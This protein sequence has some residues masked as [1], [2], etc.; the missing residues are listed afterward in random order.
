M[1]RSG[2]P[3]AG[4]RS[5][6]LSTVRR[7]RGAATSCCR[8]AACSTAIVTAR[9][10]WHVCWASAGP[11]PCSRRWYRRRRRL[12]ARWPRSAGPS[13]WRW[14][15]STRRCASPS[16]PSGSSGCW[17]TGTST[18]WRCPT[19][20]GPGSPKPCA[21]VPGWVNSLPWRRSTAGARSYWKVR[22]GNCWPRR[23]VRGGEPMPCSSGIAPGG[24]R[25]AMVPRRSAR[26]R[27]PRR[28][29]VRKEC[30][31]GSSCAATPARVSVAS[32]WRSVRRR[33]CQCAGCWLPGKTSPTIPAP[34]CST[35]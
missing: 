5:W 32:C 25:C 21:A 14:S 6:R 16:W 19:S 1:T 4:C 23:A 17:P 3:C 22:R 10:A 31:D 26:V 15:R 11:L 27:W 12:P 2:A 33:Q 28:W 18:T 8:P 34:T 7:R 29:A 35:R 30:G 24:R 13:G 9:D 20:C